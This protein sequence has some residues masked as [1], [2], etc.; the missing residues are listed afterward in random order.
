MSNTQTY[1]A[2]VAAEV[3]AELARVG[4]GLGDLAEIIGVS[5]PTAATRWNGGKG[6]TLDELYAIAVA[7]DIPVARLV[8]PS[9]ADRPAHAA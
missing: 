3:R 4:K 1:S 2:Q 5:R 9:I 7:L 6:Y 8:S